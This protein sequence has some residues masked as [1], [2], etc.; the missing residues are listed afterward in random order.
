[1]KCPCGQGNWKESTQTHQTNIKPVE[2][3]V[4]MILNLGESQ[5]PHISGGTG[6]KKHCQVSSLRRTPSF[7]FAMV[8][9]TS[10]PSRQIRWAG[11]LM[12]FLFVI[13]FLES[14]RT[15]TSELFIE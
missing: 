7:G 3:V 14:I 5:M 15:E 12:L 4:G 8:T 13:K 6:R 2:P 9:S 1:L 11:H 10:T